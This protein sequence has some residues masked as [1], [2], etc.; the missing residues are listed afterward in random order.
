MARKRRM[1]PDAAM[2]AALRS[3]GEGTFNLLA[4]HEAGARLAELMN[5]DN[6]AE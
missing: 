6:G 5:R 2:Q 1:T 3:A 4:G